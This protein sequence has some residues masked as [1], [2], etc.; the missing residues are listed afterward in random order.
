MAKYSG[1]EICYPSDIEAASRGDEL[2]CSDFITF[3]V[4]IDLV[5][6]VLDYNAFKN[7][8]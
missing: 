1:M 4:L 3:V 5:W 7:S 6:W 2:G 8:K